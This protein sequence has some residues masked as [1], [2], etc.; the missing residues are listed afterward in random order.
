MRNVWKSFSIIC[1]IAAVAAQAM[2]LFTLTPL[3]YPWHRDAFFLLLTMSIPI[4]FYL[5]IV[6]VQA[7]RLCDPESPVSSSQEK[8]T[9]CA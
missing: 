9:H 1:L 3:T 6:V 4:D 5:V 7:W 2:T 8:G